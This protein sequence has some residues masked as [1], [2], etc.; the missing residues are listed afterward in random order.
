MQ[1]FSR[2]AALGIAS[3]VMLAVATA[4]AA[5]KCTRLGF[6]VND[7]G[8]DGPTKDATRKS[9]LRKRPKSRRSSRRRKP[10]RTNDADVP[11]VMGRTCTVTHAVM[12]AQAGIKTPCGSLDR[13]GK[14]LR[15]V[16]S[17]SIAA[18]NA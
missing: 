17:D 5:A 18:G 7:Y 10:S 15:F 6:S 12:P 13:P 14:T 16:P 8:K 11:S 1:F 9:S 2:L 3:A 4:P